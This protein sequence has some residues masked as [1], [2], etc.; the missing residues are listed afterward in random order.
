M[1]LK[2]KITFD[3]ESIK[4]KSVKKSLSLL[5]IILHEKRLDMIK[6]IDKEEKINV[7]DLYNRLKMDQS[8]TSQHLGQLRNINGVTTTREG[9]CI[10]YSVNHE[11]LNEINKIATMMTK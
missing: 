2:K 1:S 11:K 6:I 8:I 3:P 7:S 5:K 4:L 9:K 10:Y